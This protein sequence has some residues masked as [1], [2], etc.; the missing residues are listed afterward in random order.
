MGIPYSMGP[1]IRFF[2]SLQIQIIPIFSLFY[3]TDFLSIDTGALDVIGVIEY[4][5]CSP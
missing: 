3:V 2:L 1:H 4:I 5:S